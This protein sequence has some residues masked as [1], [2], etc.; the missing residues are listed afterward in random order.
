MI[1][2]IVVLV[3]VASAQQ[4]NPKFNPKNNPRPNMPPPMLPPCGLPPTNI[5]DKL[6]TEIQVQLRTIWSSYVEGDEDCSSQHEDTQNVFDSLTPRQRANLRPKGPKGMCG[7]PPFID[8]LTPE[9]KQ[10]IKSIWSNYKQ[11]EEC[12]EQREAMRTV[13]DNLP[14]SEKMAL[15][16]P[17]PAAPATPV[18][19]Q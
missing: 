7:I 1:A 19:K 14:E 2:L 8:N 12:M 9:N 17:P 10:K 15:M 18:K 13:M 16:R 5:L 11:G 3:A 4:V 6:P